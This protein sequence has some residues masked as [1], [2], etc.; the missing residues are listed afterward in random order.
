VN[1]PSDGNVGAIT[2]KLD[3]S[4]SV[5]EAPF[6]MAPLWYPTGWMGD[7]GAISVSDET[8]AV[9]PND[10]DNKCTKWTYQVNTT[11]T[12]A[13]M[14]WSA[15]VYQYP[16]NNW[17]VKPGRR[18]TG[19]TKVTF[20]AKGAVGG[21]LVDFKTGSDTWSTPA[22]PGMWKD[23][24]GA[25]VNQALTTE[26]AKYEIPL[27]GANTSMAISGFIWAT[28]MGLDGAPVTFYIDEIRFE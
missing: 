13:D 25:S 16:E 21:E 11:D 27:D 10:P 19:A 20:W 14:G 3:A 2:I 28:T 22:E 8:V 5:V 23:T 24:Y 12:A 18:I 6:D 26:W 9:R 15:V 17:G 1:V 4:L 7:H